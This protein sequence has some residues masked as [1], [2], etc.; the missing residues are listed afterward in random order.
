MFAPQTAPG[1]PTT[2]IDSWDGYRASRRRVFDM[3]DALKIESFAVL[4]GDVHSSWAF[5]VAHNP[6]SGYQA[7][8]GTGSLAV[9]MVTPAISSE[10]LF[11]GPG[12]RERAPLL[13]ALQPHLKFLDGDNRG[14]VIVEIT[15]A[16][17]RSEWHFVRTVRER[18]TDEKLAAAFVCE[19]GS[20]HFEPEP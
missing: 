5:D 2:N 18:S 8:S 16:A 11:A 7:D 13:R 6:W 12:L 19:R 10:P 3:V 17:L 14:Y 1:L 20:S 15:P 4:T 9:E